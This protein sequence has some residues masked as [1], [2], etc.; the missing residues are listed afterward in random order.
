MGQHIHLVKFD[1]LASDGAANGFNYEDGSFSPEE[2]IERIRAIRKFN[3]CIGVDSGDTRDGTF[4]CP[5]AKAHP[6]FGTL[7]AQTTVQRWYAD[8]VLN[9]LGVGSNVAHS[10]HARSLWPVHSPANRSLR[11]SGG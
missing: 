11:G 4:T 6:F 8:N 10:L 1:V 2:V 3:G 7:G 9:N 5:K